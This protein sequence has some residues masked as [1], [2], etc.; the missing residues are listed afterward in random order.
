MENVNE[1]ATALI[2]A[3]KEMGSA[4][5]GSDNPFFKSKYADLSSIIEA[6]KEPLL[7]NDIAYVQTVEAEGNQNFLRTALIHKSGQ[8]ISGRMLIRPDRKSVV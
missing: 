3:Q 6:I 4:K 2:E 7:N 1:L 5:K 8:S